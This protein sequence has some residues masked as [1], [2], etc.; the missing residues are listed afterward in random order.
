[1]KA[2]FSLRRHSYL[3]TIG[4][5]LI[6]VALIAGVAGCEG[7]AEYELTMAVSPAGGG[8]ATDET[9]TSPYA[10]G[11]VVDIKAVPPDPCYRFVNWQA[12]DGTFGDA[13]NATTTFTMPARDVTVTANFEPVPPDHF[14]FYEVD[15]E[16]AP[17]LGMDVQLVDQFG[18]FNATVGRPYCSA[19]LSRRCTSIW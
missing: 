19:T 10:E 1:M 2:I 4:T 17:D 12:P 14:K 9:G 5:F 18:T 6:A 16:T 7:E 8:T 15:W 11:T 3:K 13:N